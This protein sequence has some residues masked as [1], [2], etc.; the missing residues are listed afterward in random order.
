MFC[1]GEFEHL[2]LAI[3]AQNFRKFRN[4]L[5]IYYLLPLKL[6]S[7]SIQSACPSAAAK[8]CTKTANYLRVILLGVYCRLVLRLVN[9]LSEVILSTSRHNL[10]WVAD[11][12]LHDIKN[13]TT[14]G[15]NKLWE[16]C[17][18]S[19]PSV[20]TWQ[21]WLCWLQN[22]EK[23]LLKL[24]DFR[25]IFFRPFDDTIHAPQNSN[26]IQHTSRTIQARRR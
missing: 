25:N 26:L 10:D 8:N 19:F 21:K 13:D 23:L 9:E 6:I 24:N 22:V 7:L 14:V 3:I 11:I 20:H 15:R 17:L 2:Y 18:I 4:S 12:S 5:F 16:S 1:W